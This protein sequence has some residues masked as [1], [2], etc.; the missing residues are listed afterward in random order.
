MNYAISMSIFNC[1]EALNASRIIYDNNHMGG[2]MS[3]GN[4]LKA[5]E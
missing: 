5:I 1:L 2:K 3:I 4:Y